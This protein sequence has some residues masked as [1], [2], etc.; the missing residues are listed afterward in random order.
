MSFSTL[1]QPQTFSPRPLQLKQ[2]SRTRSP[3]LF[4]LFFPEGALTVSRYLLRAINTAKTLKNNPPIKRYCAEWLLSVKKAKA[5]PTQIATA[6]HF[7]TAPQQAAEIPPQSTEL[8][9]KYHP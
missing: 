9:L 5:I 6:S 3:D 1:R 2:G 7:K 4:L 8:K